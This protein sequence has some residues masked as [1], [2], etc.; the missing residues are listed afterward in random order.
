MITRTRTQRF[1]QTL[2]LY[3]VC[4]M[5]IA[6]FG[7]HAFHGERGIN[8]KIQFQADIEMLQSE[9]QDLKRERSILARRVALLRNDSIDPDMLDLRTRDVLNF[10]HPQ[11]LVQF[12]T[13]TKPKQ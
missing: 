13:L 4:A 1:F 7:F 8:A 2:A 11:D 10:A 12:D 6:Y 5:A 3:S 9:L